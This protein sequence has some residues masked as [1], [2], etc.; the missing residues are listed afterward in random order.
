MTATRRTDLFGN[1]V[2]RTVGGPNLVDIEA[3]LRHETPGDNGAFLL[4]DG[5]KEVWVPKKLVEH[6]PHDNTFTMPEWLARDK[7]LI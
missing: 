6:D 4:F 5:T 2:S 1:P 7:G 3:E